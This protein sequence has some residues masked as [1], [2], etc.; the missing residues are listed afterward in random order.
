MSIEAIKK[1]TEKHL[2]FLVGDIEGTEI[3]SISN[4]KSFQLRK[5]LANKRGVEIVKAV[6]QITPEEEEGQ[7]GKRVIP[8]QLKVRLVNKQ[9]EYFYIE[10]YKQLRKIHLSRKEQLIMDECCETYPF[11]GIDQGFSLQSDD[12]VRK[13]PFIYDRLAAVQYA[14]RWWNDT[15][16]SFHSFDVNCTNFVSQC[17]YAGDA[18]MIG[19]PNRT[20][21]WWMQSGSWSYSWT[22]AHAMSMFLPNS[23]SGLRATQLDDPS[24]LSPGDVICYDFEGD[25]RFNHT[26]IVVAKDDNDMPLVNAQTYN[27]RMRYWSYEDS[28]AYTK[29]IRYKFLRIEDDAKVK[30]EQ[31]VI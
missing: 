14:E 12:N 17:L 23:K 15:N 16:A 6:A 29:D 24:Q 4:I 31:D 11:K 25:G 5:E 9:S 30:G 20:K 13:A 19:Y 22:V 18:M 3:S 2:Q 28:T 7:E 1:M 10:E 21:G 8:Y 27:S 26:T